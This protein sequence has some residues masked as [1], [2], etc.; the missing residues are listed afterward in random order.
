MIVIL[1]VEPLIGDAN[2]ESTGSSD[3]SHNNNSLDNQNSDISIDETSNNESNNPKSSEQ[4]TDDIP[5]ELQ[6]VFKE[7]QDGVPPTEFPQEETIASSDQ[8]F[9]S[10]VDEESEKIHASSLQ[11]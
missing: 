6:A 9:Q 7:D 10:L 5:D 11:S 2:I 1:D 3:V 8:N 4:V